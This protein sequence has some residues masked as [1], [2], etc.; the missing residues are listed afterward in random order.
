MDNEAY[1]DA[2]FERASTEVLEVQPQTDEKDF[3]DV[4]QQQEDDEESDD[5]IQ[6]TKPI[7]ADDKKVSDDKPFD[8]RISEYREHHASSNQRSILRKKKLE[9]LS[10]LGDG[11][12]TTS[13]G[14]VTAK[15]R[16]MQNG[17]TKLIQGTQDFKVPNSKWLAKAVSQSDSL[18]LINF[19]K[20]KQ[21]L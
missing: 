5:S 19:D 16:I 4:P 14:G 21:Y 10:G 1:V 17:V 15:M 3:V 13:G 18:L 20:V 9:P 12:T 2:L 7:T 8:Q 6:F 11:G